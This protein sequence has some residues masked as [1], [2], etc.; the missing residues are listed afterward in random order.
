MTDL[1]AYIIKKLKE[2]HEEYQETKEIDVLFDIYELAF[3]LVDAVEK[4][5]PQSGV[6]SSFGL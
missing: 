4:A 3:D 5:K 2:R 6:L 1:Q